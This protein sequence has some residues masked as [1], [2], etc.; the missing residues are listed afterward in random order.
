MVAI[1]DEKML[2]THKYIIKTDPL[3]LFVYHFV[4]EMKNWNVATNIA[5]R[6]DFPF[7]LC[8]YL[9]IFTT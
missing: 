9:P 2:Q 1:Y 4:F 3:S 7:H 8:F 5:V 6:L